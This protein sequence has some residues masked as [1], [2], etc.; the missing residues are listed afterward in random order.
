MIRAKVVSL[1]HLE[2]AVANAV[3]HA[4][5]KFPKV[6]FPLD[7]YG[8]EYVPIWWRIGRPVNITAAKILTN[9][10]YG[11]FINE[12]TKSLVSDQNIQTLGQDEGRLDTVIEGMGEKTWVGVGVSAR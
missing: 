5:E 6:D 10:E 12:F 8:V 9:S 4:K 3:K 7:E 11:G 2:A 1:S